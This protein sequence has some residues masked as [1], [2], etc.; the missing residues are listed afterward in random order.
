MAQHGSG[1][2]STGL[3]SLESKRSLQDPRK[4]QRSAGGTPGGGQVKRPKE[5]GQLDYARDA[6]EGVRV[7]VVSENYPESEIFE[8]NFSDIQR[9]VDRLVDELPE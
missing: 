2:T 1:S 4:R 3:K 9:A 5:F 7:A 8:E 6:R